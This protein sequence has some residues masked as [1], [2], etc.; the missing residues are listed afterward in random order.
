M[1]CLQ[2]AVDTRNKMVPSL[3]QGF[4][5]N[6]YVLASI[7]LTAGELE[8]ASHATLVERIR[9]AKNSIT[10]DYIRAYMEALEAPQISLPPLQELTMVSDWTRMPFHKLNFIH[11]EAAFVSPLV[12]P[13]TQVAYFM[14]SPT[15][16]RGI[17][18][19]IGLP[20][21]ALN[22]FSNYFFASMQ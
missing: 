16:A 20:Q 5:G 17:D 11:G 2:F 4:S 9:E 13:I 12:P 21:Q 22:A 1:V 19:R 15:E 18:V 3:P 8:K 10:T 14:Q 6:A 7:A